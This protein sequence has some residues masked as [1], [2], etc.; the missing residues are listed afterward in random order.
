[1]VEKEILK[2]LGYREDFDFD[3]KIINQD[4]VEFN[5]KKY[6]VSTVDLGLNHRYGEGKPLYWETMIF[7]KDEDDGIDFSDLYCNRYSSKENAELSH[8]QILQAFKESRATFDGNS[9]EFEGLIS[10]EDN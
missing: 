4:T 3:N 7:A 2:R 6:L 1:M 8:K 5:G 9:F 10:Y